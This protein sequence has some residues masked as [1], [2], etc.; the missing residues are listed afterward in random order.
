MAKTSPHHNG[1][2]KYV[3]AVSAPADLL[4]QDDVPLRAEVAK[5]Y[6]RLV[7]QSTEARAKADEAKAK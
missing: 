5:A 2:T 3:A 4:A 1:I 6:R 7:K